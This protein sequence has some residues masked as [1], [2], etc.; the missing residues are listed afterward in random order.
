MAAASGAM[1]LG[2]GTAAPTPDTRMDQPSA[3]ALKG[4]GMTERLALIRGRS[5]RSVPHE[6]F[7]RSSSADR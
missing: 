1:M 5:S 6:Q 2:A 3:Y 7:A 4:S